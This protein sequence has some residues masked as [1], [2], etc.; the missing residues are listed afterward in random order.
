VAIRI[1]AVRKSYGGV[2]AVDGID[3]A[4]AEGE[5]FSL[6]GPSGCG[7]TTLLRML[8]GLETPAAGRIVIGGADMAGVPPHARP[9]NM[10]FQSYA[11]FPHMSVAANVAFGLKQEGCPKAETAERVAAMLDLVKLGDLAGRKPHQLSGGQRQRVALARC[12]VKHPRVVLLDEPMAA[13]DKKLRRQ[14]QFELVRIQNQVGITFVMVTHDQEEAMAMSS[15][16]AVMDKGRI[17]QV[18]RPRDIYEHPADRFV[19]DFIGDANFFDGVVAE[20]GRVA[21]DGLAIVPPDPLPPGARVTVMVRP[22]AVQFGAGDGNRL[23]GRVA[24][25]AYHGDVSLFQVELASGRMVKVS[26]AG[27]GVERGDAV[28]LWWPAAA[29]RVLT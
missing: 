24:G 28:S 16:I 4:I 26:A 2:A 23:E 15:R 6:L 8:A 29:G 10:M 21:A 11:L 9:V 1:E 18:G 27:R 22:E 5:F 14:T 25:M 7:K 17:L 20:D 19:A 3:L 12:L 13:L